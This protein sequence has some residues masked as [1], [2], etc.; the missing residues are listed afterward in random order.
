MVGQV[1]SN[2][3]HVYVEGEQILDALLTENEAID[4]KVESDIGDIICKMDI[5]K[6][7]DHVNWELLMAVLEKM[8]FG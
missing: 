1:V 3:Q 2:H 7:Y 6:T 8:G 5:E 4:S